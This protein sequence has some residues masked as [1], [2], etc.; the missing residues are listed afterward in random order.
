MVQPSRHGRWINVRPSTYG[1]QVSAL[2]HVGTAFVTV[3]PAELPD[4]TMIATVVLTTRYRRPGLVWLGAATGFTVHVIIAVAAGSLF[5]LLPGAVVDVAAAAL[6]AAGA[7][8]LW[9]TADEPAT[10]DDGTPVPATGARQ[11]VLASAGLILVA[12]WGDLTQLAT[13]G[14]A[15]R[16]GDPLFIGLGA[17][18]ALW[19]VAALAATGGA[20]LTRVLPVHLLR[21]IAAVVFL[22]LAVVSIID[23]VR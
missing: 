2:G 15:A 6:F 17:L 4:K 1:R 18:A 22:L 11:V 20:A 14:L 23:L 16:T 8:I 21:R 12:E 19:C 13:A 3:F 5:A 10:V 7:V 9:R